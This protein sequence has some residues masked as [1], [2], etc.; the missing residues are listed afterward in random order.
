[1]NL[2]SLAEDNI[3]I[4]GEYDSAWFEGKWYTNMEMDKEANRLGNALKSIGIGK[5]DFV[6]IQMPNH[7]TVLCGF[8][9]C[10]K[11][12]AVAVPLSPLLRPEQTA[13]IYKDCGAKVVITSADYVPWIQAAQKNAPALK[14]IVVLD[15]EDIPGTIGYQ[16]FVK[17]QPDTLSCLDTDNDDVAALLYTS[18]T[19]GAPKG[20]MHTHY[21]LYQTIAGFL[22][23]SKLY[24]STTLSAKSSQFD[25]RSHKIVEFER[26]VTGLD[27][28]LNTLVVLPL[29]HSFGLTMSTTINL[30]AAKLVILKWFNPEL[31]LKTIQD[32]RI[33]GFA[34]VPV[35]YISL[36][37]HPDFDKYDLSSL[38]ACSCG[39]APLLPETGLEWQKRAGVRIIEG[40]GM[41]ETGATTTASVLSKPPRYGSIGQAVIKANTI[42][43]FDDNDNE[44]PVG[45]SGELVVKGP[46][47]MKGYLNKP[48]ETATALRNGWLHTGDIGHV[49]NEGYFWITDRKKDLIIRGGENVSPS[50]V[51]EFVMKIPQVADC[52]CIG[53]PDKKYGEEIKVYVVV[54]KDMPLKEE[55]VIAFCKQHLPTYKMPK[56]VKFTDALPKNVLGKLLR[57]ELRKIDKA[58]KS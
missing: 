35:M 28:N 54:K 32:F 4:H 33:T 56:V 43:I 9:A 49:D 52:G 10:Y 2:G 37:N 12:G 3:T 50:E 58:E 44:V 7:P 21:G 26:T 8:P 24:G 55:E 57:A 15:K 46:S 45:Q 30:A 6:V 36:L 19:T 38:I 48:D 25:I 13:Y 47:V 23:Y 20:V 42:K 51:E 29:S 11:I 41:T 40:W 22:D 18:G 39:A 34:G 14:T 5:G 1:M 31:V 27:R 53:I 16:N 17:G